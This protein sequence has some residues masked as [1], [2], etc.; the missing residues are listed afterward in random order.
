MPQTLAYRRPGA[1][2]L[3]QLSL[4]EALRTRERS[5]QLAGWTM[6]ALG[7]AALLIG[8]A[9]I[10][11]FLIGLKSRLHLATAIDWGA[12]FAIAFAAM[13]PLLFWM[14]L[15]TRGRW[16]EDEMRSQGT[17]PADLWQC[18]SRG[19]WE[20][21]TTAAGWAAMM[22]ILLWGPRMVLGARERFRASVPTAVM[23]DATAVINYLRHFDDGIPTAELPIHRPAAALR[24]LVSRDWAGVSKRGDRVWLLS[25]ARRTLGFS[26]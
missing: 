10:A 25:E 2:E 24:Y 18:S 8:P 1:V 15:R 17:T 4:A 23:A 3:S 7:A 9:L 6:L 14:E 19:E 5:Y 16:F 26:S 20:L 11:S 13:V 21:R 22:E 12:C